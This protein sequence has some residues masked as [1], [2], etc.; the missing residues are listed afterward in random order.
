M[1]AF[2]VNPEN[3]Y[4]YES[5]NQPED[6]FIKVVKHIKTILKDN[7]FS[8]KL[9]IEISPHGRIHGH[10]WIWIDDPLRFYTMTIP[11]I[12]SYATI[13]I[14]E[15]TDPDGWWEYCT[16]MSHIIYTWMKPAYICRM[17]HDKVTLS[18]LYYGPLPIPDI[19]K[20]L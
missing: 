8:Y 19:E 15:I 1:Y 11:K 10:G 16:K 5:I 20:Y 12:E 2:T 3:Q 14:S 6:R 13:D 17:I 7:S 18:D 9:Y 4:I